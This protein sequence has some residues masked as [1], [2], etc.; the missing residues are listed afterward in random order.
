MAVPEGGVCEK[1]DGSYTENRI[2][3]DDSEDLMLL[4]LPSHPKIYK[5]QLKN[6]LRFVILPNKVP[7]NR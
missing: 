2:R 5:G 7:L 3:K 1:F 4:K 6:G